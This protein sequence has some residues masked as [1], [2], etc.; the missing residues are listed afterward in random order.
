[1]LFRIYTTCSMSVFLK[2]RNNDALLT[3]SFRAKI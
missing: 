2:M 3:A 1:M